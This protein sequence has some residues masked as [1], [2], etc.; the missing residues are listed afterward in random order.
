M[1]VTKFYTMSATKSRRELY[2][3]ATRA[4][5]IEAATR[6]FAS[7]GFANTALEDIAADINATRGAVYHHFSNK[8]ALF[9]A[10]H[11][12]LELRAVAKA[13]E[14]AA[15]AS[16][17]WAGGLAALDAFLDECLDPVYSRVVWREAPVALGW[18]EWQEAGETYA[19]GIIEQQFTAL[20][21]GGYIAPAPIDT[22]TRIWF[23]I[24]GAAGTALA[25]AAP[26]D[27]HRLRAEYGDM[28]KQMMTGLRTP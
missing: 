18:A 23:S 22:A 7:D 25:Q 14:A 26:E 17:P 5:L 21:A 19:F 11:E 27:Q 28:I 10:V 12:T 9:K 20:I 3:E 2:S 24:L 4:A 1:Y 8:R 16:D 15:A 13:G 6:R